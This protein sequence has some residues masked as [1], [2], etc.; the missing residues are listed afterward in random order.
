AVALLAVIRLDAAFL[1]LDAGH[2]AH[3]L[4]ACMQLAQ[5]AAVITLP[6]SDPA[7]LPNVPARVALDERG[8]I[9]TAGA[10]VR[11]PSAVPGPEGLRYVAFTS[12][13]TGVPRGVMGA[14]APVAHFL[15]WYTATF[16]VGPD[17]R[18]AMLSGI[19][20]DPLLRDVLAPL[21]TGG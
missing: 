2:P 20:H 1:V 5:P 13:T 7:A 18:F 4:A 9:R 11:S 15:D 12:G 21:C 17:D 3:R 16:G 8:E 19:S 6:A 14:E 10:I